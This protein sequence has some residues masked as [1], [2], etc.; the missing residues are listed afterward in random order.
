MLDLYDPDRATTHTIKGASKLAAATV[1]DLLAGIGST[2]AGNGGAGLAFLAEESE[3]SDTRPLVGRL[4]A[5]F[6]QRSL[7]GI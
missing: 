7:G 4:R 3:F 2:F 6:P 1:N 5:K